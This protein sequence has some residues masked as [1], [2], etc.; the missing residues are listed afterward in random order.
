[1]KRLLLLVALAG[2]SISA[3]GCAE[4]K[5]VTPPPPADAKPD[6]AKPDEPTT[7][8]PDAAA[9]APADAGKAP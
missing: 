4:N 5:P 9:P 3:F 7:P 8:A 6:A 1:M 2:F